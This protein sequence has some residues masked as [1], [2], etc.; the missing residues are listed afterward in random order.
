MSPR[1][2]W[3]RTSRT[4]LELACETYWSPERTC[5]YHRRKKTTA[6][7][8]SATPPSTATRRAICG[9]IGGR[10]SSGSWIIACAWVAGRACSQR[11]ETWSGGAAASA[12]RVGQRWVQPAPRDRVDRWRD[13]RVDEDGGDDL[14]EQQPADRGVDAEQELHDRVAELRAQRRRGADRQQRERALRVTH[15]AQPA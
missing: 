12:H 13:E 9:L 3:M 15:L 4:W 1:G 5:R 7:R 8:T 11:D 6:K 10:R 14:A 2:A